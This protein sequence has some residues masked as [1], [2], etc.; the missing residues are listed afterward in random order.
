[1]AVSGCLVG[2]KCRYDGLSKAAIDVKEASIVAVCPEQLGGLAT[3]RPPAHFV[4]GTGEEVIAGTA[5]V[6]NARGEDVTAAYLRGAREIV[7][8]CKR[9]NIRKAYL[10]EKS[11]SC[12][13]RFVTVEGKLTRGM[14]V[15][16]AMLRKARVR[17]VSVP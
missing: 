10:K 9:L 8:I 14:G 3:P 1:V 16:A 5:R 11:P 7:A 17:L 6:V 2:V 15:A 13:T 12:G 4:G